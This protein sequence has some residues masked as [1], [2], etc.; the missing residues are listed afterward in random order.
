M[1]Y[2]LPLLAFTFLRHL[3]ESIFKTLKYN[4]LTGP[5]LFA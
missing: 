2:I 5:L 4:T 1:D 3:A